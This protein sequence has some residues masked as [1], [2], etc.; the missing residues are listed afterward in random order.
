[1]PMLASVPVLDACA[2]IGDVERRTGLAR[3]SQRFV[4][5]GFALGLMREGVRG[6]RT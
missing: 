6:P 2:A 5:N 4:A 3:R 1:M